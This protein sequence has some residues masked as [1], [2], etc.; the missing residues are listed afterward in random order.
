MKQPIRIHISHIPNTFNYG[1]AMMAIALIDHLARLCPEDLVFYTDASSPEDLERLRASTGLSNIH[2]LPPYDG[3]FTR[4]AEWKDMPLLKKL[5][6]LPSWVKEWK[7]KHDYLV[8]NA[9]FVVI[10]GGDDLSEYYGIR[11][12]FF[13]MVN[14]MYLSNKI[15][16]FLLGQTIGPFFSYRKKLASIALSK[17]N[18]FTRDD[19]TCAYCK[20]LGLKNVSASR[21]LAFLNLPMQND[22][23]KQE[24]VLAKYALKTGQYV[25]VVGSGLV[26]HYTNNKSDFID[27]FVEI[28]QNLSDK[29]NI[30]R[31]VFLAH[32]FKSASGSDLPV[33]REILELLEKRNLCGVLNKLTVIDEEMLPYESRIILGNG[34]WTITGRMHAAISTLQMG[35]PAIAISYSVKYDGVLKN[36]MNIPEL[37]V[38]AFDSKKWQN[39]GIAHEVEKRINLINAEYDSTCKKIKEKAALCKTKAMCQINTMIN[40]IS[41]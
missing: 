39:L 7:E 28:M 21:D 5:F 19:D 8:K 40:A 16:L 15:P 2:V 14:I 30:K 22:Q 35:K 12:L 32:V 26:G 37:V 17:A 41:N 3:G 34:R 13:E 33:M 31:I 38:D 1:S 18:I 4:P 29:T 10:L 27:N 25:T 11:G 9:D 24:L 20:T 36:G 23:D 6:Y